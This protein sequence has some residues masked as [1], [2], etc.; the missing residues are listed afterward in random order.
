[1]TSVNIGHNGGPDLDGRKHTVRTL[2]AKALFADPETPVYVM[3]IAWAIHWYSRA[4]GSGAALSNEQ[5]MRI[6]GISETTA[7]RGKRWLRDNG[8]VQ[9]T[10]GK[11]DQK[12]TFRMSIPD[13][14][15]ASTE[16][17]GVVPQTTLPQT[18]PPQ[19]TPG[20]HTDH[21]G[22]VPRLGYIQERD[23]RPI[24]Y[25]GDDAS[26]RV[27]KP[28]KSGGNA[29][30][31]NVINPPHSDYVFDGGK[32]TLL[33]GTRS[34]WLVQFGEDARRLDLALKEV[35]AQVQP[36]GSKPL[37]VQVE[38]ALSRIAG[39]KLDSAENYNRVVAANKAAAAKPKS[40][41][42]RWG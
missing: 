26:L 19:T 23:S 3:A 15:E 17:D 11:G 24:R 16:D 37:E 25:Q 22:V 12:T 10:V 27:K 31:K 14:A 8:Y 28:E 1:M 21:P 32:L 42:S 33:N 5:L 40:K 20:N 18:T 29:F 41:P 2:W 13:P 34:E 4:D 30:W 39:R 6:C 35:A 38:A 36:N 7:T 9:L